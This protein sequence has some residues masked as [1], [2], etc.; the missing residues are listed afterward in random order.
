MKLS[1]VA[2][3]REHR[4]GPDTG[5]GKLPDPEGFGGHHVG[6]MTPRD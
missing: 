6:E 3:G 5:S 2:L 1:R 4:V